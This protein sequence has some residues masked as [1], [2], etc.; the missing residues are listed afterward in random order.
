MPSDVSAG[1]G[2]ATWESLTR[3]SRAYTSVGVTALLLMLP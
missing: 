3:R 2:N 1:I